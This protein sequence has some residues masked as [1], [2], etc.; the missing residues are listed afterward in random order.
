[1]DLTLLSKKHQ[2]R[3]FMADKKP[4]EN[5]KSTLEDRK[6]RRQLRHSVKAGAD[7]RQIGAEWRHKPG[8]HKQR[9]TKDIW[10]STVSCICDSCGASVRTAEKDAGQT[11]KC[12]CGHRVRVP[13]VSAKEMRGRSVIPKRWFWIPA[14]VVLLEI[15]AIAYWLTR[16][17]EAAVVVEQGDMPAP[18]LPTRLEGKEM[19]VRFLEAPTAEDKLEFVR[20]A[21]VMH[22]SITSYYAD[23]ASAE[24]DYVSI[25]GFGSVDTPH[26]AFHRYMVHYPN[27]RKRLAVIVAT[28]AGPRIDWA[29]FSRYDHRLWPAFWKERPPVEMSAR[30]LTRRGSYYNFAFD[31]DE[32][33][34]CF[35]LE[36]PDF[37]PR[38]QGYV[39]KGTELETKIRQ[40]LARKKTQRLI[41]RLRR[42]ENCPSERL[43]VRIIGLELVGW[44][45]ET[46][47]EPPPIFRSAE[48]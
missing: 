38:M 14:A 18:T 34:T 30:V 19:L 13:K 25:R 10:A 48:L 1:M 5:T 31:S 39:R 36:S 44:T 29:T 43:Q 22:D 3:A 28:E 4:S 32:K 40:A 41:L 35:K 8:M 17:P 27:N 12:D 23:K 2:T 42:D 20:F 37:P 47:E 26:A 6:R 16:S 7:A 46:A 45:R 21:S 15:L 11:L 24:E 33:W 9:K